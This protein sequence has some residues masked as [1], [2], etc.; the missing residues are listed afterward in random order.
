MY[1]MMEPHNAEGWK[2]ENSP[3]PW[4]GHGKDG[5]NAAFCDGHASWIG[6]KKWKDT[7]VRSQDYPSSYPLAP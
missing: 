6:A 2:W 7:A 3:N 5:G 1:D 4:D